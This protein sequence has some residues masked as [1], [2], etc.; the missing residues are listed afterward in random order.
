MKILI[1]L[2]GAQSGSRYRGIG[3][4]SLAL[5]KELVKNPGAQEY[6]LLVNARLEDGLLEIRREF[7]GIIPSF[8]IRSFDIPV[9][10]AEQDRSNEWRARAAEIA[11]T[12]AIAKI[13]PEVVLVSSLFEGYSFDAAVSIDASSPWKTAVVLY[14][15]IPFLNPSQY[16]GS[17]EQKRHYF[18]KI[19]DL[20]RADLLLA[21]SEH[22]KDEAI[23]A[24]SIPEQK[25]V[26]ISAAVDGRFFSASSVDA[27]IPVRYGVQRKMVLYVPGGFDARKNFENLFAAFAR[28]PQ[29]IRAIYQL[30]IASKLGQPERDH[31]RHLRIQAGLAEEDLVLTGY[32]PDEDLVQLYKAASLFIFPSTH[33]GFGLPILEAMACGT[34]AIGANSTSIPEV[35]DDPR[36]LF[37]PSSINSIA[38]KIGQVLDDPLW[39][40]ELGRRGLERAKMFSWPRT[41]MLA[42]VAIEEK[43][44]SSKNARANAPSASLASLGEV[45]DAV[46]RIEA[47]PPP[48]NVD[49]AALARCLVFNTNPFLRP[50]ILIDVSVIVLSDVKSGIQRVVRSLV[51]NLLDAPPADFFIQP[52]YFSKGNY[53]AANE[54]ADSMR[55]APSNEGDFVVDVCQ[56][57]IYLGLDLSP[58]LTREVHG[59]HST[60]QKRGVKSYFVIYDILPALRPDWWSVGVGKGFE[61]WLESIASVAHGLICI[62]GAVADEVRTWLIAHGHAQ[63]DRPI[64]T[65]FRLGADVGASVPTAGMPEGAEELLEQLKG[66]S[67]FLMVGTLEPRKGYKQ[68]IE[69]FDQLWDEGVESNLIIVGR[70]GWLVDLLIERIRSHEYSGRRL[71]WLGQISDE[72]LE[73]IYATSTCLIAASE[74]EGFGLPLVEA[75]QH[76]LPVIARDLPVFREVA[77]DSAFYF[78]GTSAFDLAD[79]IQKWLGMNERGAAPSSEKMSC[80]SWR[81]SADELIS[82]IRRCAK[83]AD[84]I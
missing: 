30:V 34:P 81:Q 36:A 52:I 58:H 63:L 47:Y 27:S 12:Q 3:R 55:V 31:L 5:A 83:N 51:K 68:A 76:H 75:A 13:N 78:S 59:I 38:E 54:F 39:A 46:A 66:K 16:F 6:W 21:I 60:W 82:V 84:E 18:R 71:F 62:S 77:A 33:E 42:R 37:D 11:R 10:V 19:D 1:D 72:Y 28:Q 15:L 49:L 53:W 70:E 50:R 22:S 79:C 48:R 24:L 69:A 4:Y 74:G 14:D 2:Q 20:K 35:V 32:V 57:D 65:N 8:R 56:D 17:E 61:A 41:G 73:K 43:L 44:G 23:E 26:N 80:I 25:I 9:P 45:I 7:D 67:N 40:A 64:V 29:H